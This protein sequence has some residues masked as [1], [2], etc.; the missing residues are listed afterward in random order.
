MIDVDGVAEC[1]LRGL[2]NSLKVHRNQM[3]RSGYRTRELCNGQLLLKVQVFMY[4]V[5]AEKMI[6]KRVLE[7]CFSL[8]VSFFERLIFVL[9]LRR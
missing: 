3:T 7:P 2:L 8:C 5:F 1:L 9:D 6:K 4:S